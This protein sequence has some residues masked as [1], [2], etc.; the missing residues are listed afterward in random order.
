MS[1][2]IRV[3]LLIVHSHPFF[4]LLEIIWIHLIKIAFVIKLLR[5]LEVL[6]L[7][8][9]SLIKSSILKF[10]ICKII[11]HIRVNI[12]ID[13][14]LLLKIILH[15]IKLFH[16]INLSTSSK[17]PLSFWS[18]AETIHSRRIINKS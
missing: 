11:V 15:L 13:L 10:W 5:I 7:I 14:I 16:I 17:T 3:E 8:T 1:W 4:L 9:L 2:E 18:W 6:L 12:W